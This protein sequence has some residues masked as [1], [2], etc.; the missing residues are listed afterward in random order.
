[1]SS[2]QV[3]E[4]LEWMYLRVLTE[5]GSAVPGNTVAVK[6]ENLADSLRAA[7]VKMLLGTRATSPVICLDKQ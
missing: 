4:A 5:Y 1:M 3:L 2:K 7:G 6:V